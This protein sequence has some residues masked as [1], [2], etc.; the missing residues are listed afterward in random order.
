MTAILDFTSVSKIYHQ[1]RRTVQALHNVSFNVTEGEVFGFVGPNGAGK[2]TTIKIM[3]DV[4]R[5]YSGQV[6]IHGID[7][8]KPES[9]KG[10]SYLPES[11]ALYEQFTPLEILQMTLRMYGIKRKDS[12]KWCM[13]WLE[14]F[15]LL[16]YAER[17]VR[18]LSKGN[19]QRTALASV[20]V[21]SP[22]LLVL[23]EPLSGL[24]PVGRK[25]V[26]DILADYKADGGAI[27]FTSHVLHDVERVADR[28]GLINEG[29]LVTIRKPK[30]FVS[31][32][33]ERLV[34]RYYSNSGEVTLGKN[35]RDTE[36]EHELG[37]SELPAFI[38][39]INATHGRIINIKP[40]TSLE[41]MFFKLIEENTPTGNITS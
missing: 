41:S 17:R 31:D 8:R 34:V 5:D 39:Q 16:Q 7:A 18:Q 36:Y 24:D 21:S 6:C 15:S 19:V 14:R 26:I 22:K 2:S 1:K 28:F 12:T 25:D 27:F 9:R 10:V 30:D 40:A 4:I 33:S 13:E 20:M 35:L 29:Q 32:E 3:L 37:Q 38:E 23:D 11:P